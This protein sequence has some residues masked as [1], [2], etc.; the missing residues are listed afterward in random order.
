LIG[1]RPPSC[2]HL[3]FLDDHL[4]GNPKFTGAKA[5]LRIGRIVDLKQSAM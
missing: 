5:A 3:Y 4:F 2:R 1:D